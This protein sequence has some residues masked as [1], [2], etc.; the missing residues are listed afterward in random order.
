VYEIAPISIRAISFFQKTSTE[1][2]FILGVLVLIISQLMKA[3]SKFAFILIG[4][5]AIF[6][7]FFT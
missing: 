7:K 2:G 5:I 3:M 1:F 4:A 6:H